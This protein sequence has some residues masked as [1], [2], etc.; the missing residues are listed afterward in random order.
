MVTLQEAVLASGSWDKTVKLWD[1]FSGK[2]SRESV[3]VEGDVVAIAFR[4]DGKQLVSSTL[5]GLLEVWA[6]PDLQL[7]ASI[8][9]RRDLLGGRMV[10]DK[11][12]GGCSHVA[13]STGQALAARD[14]NEGRSTGPL[15]HTW[16]LLP[17]RLHR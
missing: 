5:K 7:S 11:V 16:H 14:K 3:T 2:D 10:T 9:G 13:R 6:Y 4:P 15:L 8:D 1:V 12:C 17:S